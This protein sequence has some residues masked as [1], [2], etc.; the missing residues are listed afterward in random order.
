MW[1]KTNDVDIFLTIIYLLLFILCFVLFSWKL[2][3]IVFLIC[4]I[5][6]NTKKV[7]Y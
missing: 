7:Q 4:V 3:L 6:N 5:A 2:A 1:Y